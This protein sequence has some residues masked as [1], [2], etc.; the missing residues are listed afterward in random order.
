[1]AICVLATNWKHPEQKR[2]KNKGTFFTNCL[3]AV[4][5]IEDEQFTFQ[6]STEAKL[7]PENIQRLG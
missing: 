4:P 2:K 1:M 3:K 7:A 6:T 5:N